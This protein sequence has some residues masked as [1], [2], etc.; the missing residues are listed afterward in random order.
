MGAGRGISHPIVSCP[1]EVAMVT[2]SIKIKIQHG[3]MLM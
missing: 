1:R 2:Q 3:V